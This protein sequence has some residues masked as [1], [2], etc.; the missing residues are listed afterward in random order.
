MKNN[1]IYKYIKFV[2]YQVQLC[3]KGEAVYPKTMN[4]LPQRCSE[5]QVSNYGKKYHANNLFYEYL[6]NNYRLT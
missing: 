5:K 3:I 6:T 4:S 2:E 1:F